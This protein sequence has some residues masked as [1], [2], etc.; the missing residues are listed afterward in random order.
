ML[1]TPLTQVIGYDKASTI[2][3][4]AH[5]QGTNLRSAALDLGYI[6]AEAFD[7][8]VNPKA[9]TNAEN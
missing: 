5:E 3:K 1:V 9:M 6:S 8:I 4:Y 7:Q 2:A